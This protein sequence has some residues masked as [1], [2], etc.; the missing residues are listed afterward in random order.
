MRNIDLATP[1]GEAT[2]QPGEVRPTASTHRW[3][4][5]IWLIYLIDY[6]DR[7]AVSAVLPAIQQEFSLDDAQLG[8][9]SGSL[10]LGLA[11]L[12]VPC[13]LAVDR[14]SRKYMI[15]IMTLVWS[16]AT[17]STGLAKSFGDLVAARILVGAGEAGYNP[18]G[19]SLIA[20]WYPQRL[21]GTMVGLFN[22]AQPLG[23]GLGIV[24]AGH[25]AEQ[26]GWRAVF[27]L[28]ALPGVILALLML[29][30]PDYK[31]RK[32]E[33]DGTKTIKPGLR[34][35]LGYIANNR[36][37]QLIY[38][39]QLP[40]AIYINT[41]AIWGPTLF[42]RQYQLSLADAAS[43]VGIITIVAGVGALCGGWYSDRVSRGNPGAR[44]TVCVLYLAV[45]L[46]LHSVTFIGSM[47][48]F[49][50]TAVVACFCFGQFFAAANWGTLVAASLDQSPPPYRA[51]CQSFLPMFQAVAAVL[52]GIIS[53]LLSKSLGLPMTMEILLVAGMLVAILILREARRHYDADYQ[54]Q[55]D[56]GA[57]TL[58]F[59]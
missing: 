1:G 22:M 13:G 16:L 50:L 24:L 8:L 46:A 12:A 2:E 42:V 45:P 44:V 17:W 48:G 15:T 10:F 29:F 32:I 37:L 23:V 27:G 58:E 53:G 51:S 38:L 5:V 30:A 55:G 49:S 39:A 25:L 4:A 18:A 31:T 34:D 35:T 14:F 11:M 54:R 19:Y 20:A 59:K 21:R 3:F 41:C 6:A 9:M 57:I 52:A 33:P 47:R 7:F 40:I 36:T 43:M 28:L 26:F 56:L